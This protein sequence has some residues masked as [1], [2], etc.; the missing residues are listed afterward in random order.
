MMPTPDHLQWLA[1]GALG[2]LSVAGALWAI[3]RSVRTAA[4]HDA[5]NSG[6]YQGYGALVSNL[7]SEVNRL[8]AEVDRLSTLTTSQ[9]QRILVLEHE[10]RVARADRT[11]LVEMLRQVKHVQEEMIRAGSLKDRLLDIPT[12]ILGERH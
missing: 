6:I 9:M 12:N 4:T 11:T 2:S 10:S 3:V 1:T 8:R 7:H 5:A